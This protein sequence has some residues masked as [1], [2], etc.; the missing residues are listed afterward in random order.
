MLITIL[1]VEKSKQFTSL[2]IA[3]VAML[4]TH[5]PYY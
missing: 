1:Q 4:T 2:T 5:H 3:A